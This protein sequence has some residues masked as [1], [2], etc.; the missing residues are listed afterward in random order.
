[1]QL[2]FIM[3]SFEWKING[4]LLEAM[5]AAEHGTAF[6]SPTF[7]MNSCIF[8]LE[9]YPN[10]SGYNKT[11]TPGI[12]KVNLHVKKGQPTFKKMNVVASVSFLETNKSGYMTLEILDSYIKTGSGLGNLQLNGMENSIIQ[13]CQSL[14]TIKFRME[15]IQT[16]D[17]DGND[18]THVFK[19][20]D[21]FK[22]PEKAS[23]SIISQIEALWKKFDIMQNRMSQIELKI[24]EEQK[25]SESKL[26]EE[27]MNKLDINVNNNNNI[28]TKTQKLKLWLEHEVKCPQYLNVFIENAIDDLQTASLLTMDTIKAMGIDKIG[29]QIKIFH[30]VTKLKEKREGSDETLLL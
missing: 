11:L 15:V 28:D 17:H 20:N 30:Q 13:Q 9:I 2:L 1:M 21:E 12:V 6:H 26:T 27:N 14:F 25:W 8:L 19:K 10:H 3:S 23:H 29:H 18:I 16:F 24:N 5:K 22:Q 4:L 7:N